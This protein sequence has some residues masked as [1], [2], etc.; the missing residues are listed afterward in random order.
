VTL[1]AAAVPEPSSILASVLVFGLFGAV[2]AF[3]RS[4]QAALVA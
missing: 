1:T 2:W 3:K 4:R